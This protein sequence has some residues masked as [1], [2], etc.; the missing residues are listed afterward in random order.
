MDL[1]LLL[2]RDRYNDHKYC[3]IT[4]QT[5]CVS[6]VIILLLGIAMF[7]CNVDGVKCNPKGKF[8]R[9]RVTCKANGKLRR[10]REALLRELQPDWWVDA[11]I[12]KALGKLSALED[13]RFSTWAYSLQISVS[14]SRG[15]YY[16]CSKCGDSGAHDRCVECGG[17]GIAVHGGLAALFDIGSGCRY[18]A[19]WESNELLEEHAGIYAYDKL[20]EEDNICQHHC[21][22]NSCACDSHHADHFCKQY[23]N[24][25]RI[26]EA[27]DDFSGDQ[28]SDDSSWDPGNVPGGDSDG[29][30]DE[31]VDSVNDSDGDQMDLESVGDISSDSD[32]DDSH[33]DDDVDIPTRVKFYDDACDNCHRKAMEQRNSSGQIDCDRSVRLRVVWLTSGA[34]QR[35]ASTMKFSAAR[36]AATEVNPGY[37]KQKSVRMQLC[38]QCRNGLT[39]QPSTIVEKDIWPAM[40]WTWLTDRSLL[41]RFGSDLWKIVPAEWRRW[42]IRAVLDCI[43]QF[44]HVTVE[45]P[46]PIFSDVTDRKGEFEEGI[47]EMRAVEMR[48]VC[49]EHLLPLV[50]CPW[51]CSEYFH[52]CGT[53]SIDLVIRK[54][55]GS[56]VTP[57]YGGEKYARGGTAKMEGMD[58]D[59]ADV[60]HVPCLLG[61]RA[62]RVVPSIAFVDGI[63]RVLSCRNHGDGSKGKCLYPPRNPN[64]ILSSPMA[65]QVA[66]AVVRPR[67]VRQFKP[68][69]YS[70]TFQMSEMQGQ[71][72]GVDTFHL[73]TT[74]NFESESTLL[75]DNEVLAMNGRKDILSLVTEWTDPK[76]D[77]L[78]CDVAEEMIRNAEDSALPDDVLEECCQSATY[79]T[80]NDAIK[81]YKANKECKGRVVQIKVKGKMVDSHYVPQWPSVVIHVH[82]YNPWG[83]EFPLL[84]DM[85]QPEDDW[86]LLWSLSAMM[87]GVPSLWEKT[88]AIVS[89]CEGWYGWLLAYLTPSCFPQS[90]GRGAYGTE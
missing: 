83:C 40:M 55:F 73:T 28:E 81:L 89:N 66:P 74:R 88:D 1:Q 29:G 62:W 77:V 9:S 87:I 58:H 86:H 10:S 26:V 65:D 37:Y 4:M 6:F 13:H 17:K 78:P 51:G 67:T 45:N 61:N 43:P 42:W 54:I 34:F 33:N 19:N 3:R 31:L 82:P 23:C 49:N 56:A 53:L 70:D 57:V 85:Q 50:R 48:R 63:P 76:S 90:Q 18:D 21:E 68:H 84:L 2:S 80:L 59:Y 8:L 35:R 46:L 52:K 5:S 41:R 75:R 32:D 16:I 14:A 36:A 22:L 39:I 30:E 12:R 20:S 38:Q 71:F 7:D 47:A 15:C 60:D 69:A 44:H 72:A 27:D 79:V 24:G 64:S 25:T 11:R